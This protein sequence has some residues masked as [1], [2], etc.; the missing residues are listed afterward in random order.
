MNNLINRFLQTSG[1][2]LGDWNWATDV[3]PVIQD[4]M[5]NGLVKSG[6]GVIIGISIASM[7]A[8]AI[9]SIFFSRH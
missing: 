5:N 6:I 8:R 2:G 9:L 7:G 4:F 1:T 3:N